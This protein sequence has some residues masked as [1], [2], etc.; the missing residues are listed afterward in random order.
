MTCDYH[1][2]GTRRAPRTVTAA[3]FALTTAAMVVVTWYA[4]GDQTDWASLSNDDCVERTCGPQ[5]VDLSDLDYV[6]EPIYVSARTDM[7]VHRLAW[8]VLVTCGLSM[9]VLIG[10][11]RIRP[12]VLAQLV[13]ALGAAAFAGAALRSATTAFV[14]GIIFGGLDVMAMVF[15]CGLASVLCWLIQRSMNSRRADVDDDGVAV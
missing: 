14:G 6:I 1:R 13:I 10:M 15:V 11:R 9:L 2:M 5:N 12:H 3:L 8:V 7:I 4:V